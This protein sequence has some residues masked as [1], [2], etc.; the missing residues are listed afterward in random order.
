MR[1]LTA[2]LLL[3]C[4]LVL[5]G[6]GCSSKLP[7]SGLEVELVKLDRAPDGVVTATLQFNNSAV[8]AFNIARSKHE[9]YLN[10]RPAGTIDINEPLGLPQQ[11]SLT[12]TG[13]LHVAPG[14]LPAGAAS[15]RLESALTVLLYG[16]SKDTIKLSSAGTVQVP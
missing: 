2:P 15:Y 11:R 1:R 13:T 10:D 16:D 5:L 7:P 12:Q 8:L 4:T 9:L 6:G 3:L 14:G